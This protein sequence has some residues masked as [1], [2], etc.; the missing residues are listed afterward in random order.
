MQRI[1]GLI[2]MLFFGLGQ[3]SHSQTSC[4]LSKQ[5][6]AQVPDSIRKNTAI[7]FLDL[8]Y[9]QLTSLPNWFNELSNLKKLNLSG[10]IFTD[11]GKIFSQLAQLPQLDTLIWNEGQLVYLP[12]EFNQLLRLKYLSLTKNGLVKLPHF[13]KELNLKFLDLSDNLI[14]T[15]SASLVNLSHL[16]GLHLSH[17]PN[18]LNDHSIQTLHF[19]PKL[20]QLKLGGM[21]KIPPPITKLNKLQKLEIDQTGIVDL[22]IFENFKLL[23]ELTLSRCA[24]LDLAK[25]IETM[26]GWSGLKTLNLIGFN[27]LK[28]PYNLKKLRSLEK[29]T[30]SN[31]CISYLPDAISESKIKSIELVEVQFTQTTNAFDKM[32][33]I[34]TL[35]TFKLIDVLCPAEEWTF[36]GY[37]NLENLVIKNCNLGNLELNQASLREIWMQGT[38]INCPDHARCEGSS[39]SWKTPKTVVPGKTRISLNPQLHSY[40]RIIYPS[41][42][43]EFTIQ[44]V[45]FRIAPLSFLDQNSKVISEEEITVEIQLHKKPN[46]IAMNQFPLADSEG[47]PLSFDWI[48]EINFHLLDGTKVFVDPSKPIQI[49]QPQQ[50][51]NKARAYQFYPHKNRWSP[52]A[53]QYGECD[54]TSTE[55]ESNPFKA[56]VLEELPKLPVQKTKVRRSKVEMRI[57]RNKRKGLMN[58]EIT[59]EYGYRESFFQLYGQKIKGYPELKEYKNIKWK[60]VGDSLDKDLERLYF[61]SDQA[62]KDKLERKSTF[63][64]YVLDIEDI[65]LNPAISGD[66]YLMGIVQGSDTIRLKVLPYLAISSAKKIQK[67]HQRK[68]EDYLEKLSERRT[69]WKKLDSMQLQKEEQYDQV[70]NAFRN[71]IIRDPKSVQKLAKKRSTEPSHKSM[72]FNCVQA[73]SYGIGSAVLVPDAREVQLELTISDRHHFPK[74]VLIYHRESQQYYWQERKNASISSIGTSFVLS[75][76]GNHLYMGTIKED[77][78]VALERL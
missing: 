31:C 25:A 60:Y 13:A 76:V 50:Q 18:I 27:D 62:K 35:R 61:L 36:K 20:Q 4:S 47:L 5:N 16:E 74:E 66:H 12:F 58:F 72:I 59:P 11:A 39:T 6:L 53:F 10:N 75:A 2:L 64:F 54:T 41:V 7:Q 34:N 29:L 15:L 78:S 3:A 70:I 73:G 24:K 52:V 63:Y 40:E 48:I 67:W 28:L 30:L 57:K 77:G 43:E 69:Y 17:N 68:Y 38:Q 1:F 51:M 44:G 45:G 46:P 42:G 21:E 23:E 32:G 71:K 49:L 65:L 19:L 8:S 56:I 37:Q 26:E 33:K 14:D 55:K 22:K 9:N